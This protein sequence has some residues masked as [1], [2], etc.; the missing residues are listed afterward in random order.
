M[1]FIDN[2]DPTHD[3]EASRP[4]HLMTIYRIDW[5][6]HF[7]EQL[8]APN[9]GYDSPDFLG[10]V[11]THSTVLKVLLVSAAPSTQP[12]RAFTFSSWRCVHI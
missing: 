3:H 4:Q 5:F 6:F 10:W 9:E 11:V 2:Y 8:S 7:S 1:S 12:D